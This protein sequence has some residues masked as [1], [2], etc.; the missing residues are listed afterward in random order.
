MSKRWIIGIVVVLVLLVAGAGAA[1]LVVWKER[2]PGTIR[3]SG[4]TEFDTTEEPGIV[5]RPETQVR[6][7]P[8]PTYGYDGERS[9]FA[10]EFHLRPPFRQIWKRRLFNLIEFPPVVAY[11]NLYLA[12]NGGRLFAIDA[13]TGKLVWD[14]RSNHCTAAAPTVADGVIYQPFMDAKPCGEPRDSPGFI[15]AYDARNGH[16]L[17]RFEAG[18]IETSPLLVGKLLYFGSWDKK[19]YAVDIDTHKVVWSFTTGDEVKG[20]PA[21]SDGTLYF[22]S[23]DSKVYAVNARSGKLLWSGSGTANFYATPTVAYG[24]VYI[25]NTDGRVYAFGADSGH[26]LWAKAT[27]GYVYSSAGV[28]HRKV[29]VGSFS[30]RFFALDA[31]SGD[32]VWSFPAN[33]PISGAPTILDGVVYFSTIEGKTYAL[34]AESGKKLWEFGDGKYSPIVADEER[35]Y[36]TGYKT[37]YGLVPSG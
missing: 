1:A 23:Y 11:G 33:G 30:K 29:F 2:N 3:G 19:M 8:W 15:A 32:V 13:K 10:P 12:N 18:V 26:L 5:T 24:R 20:A 9:R 14:K 36:L 31:G 6:D 27:G 28:W 37:I 7:I 35:V 21:Y 4:S 34:D 17:W 16:E 22:A 25:G